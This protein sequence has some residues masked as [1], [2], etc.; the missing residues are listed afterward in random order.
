MNPAFQKKIIL[1]GA[2]QIVCLIAMIAWAALPVMIGTEVL[3][4]TRPVDPRDL[5]RGNYVALQYD[6]SQIPK[7]LMDAS[8]K[9][10]SYS[11]RGTPVFVRLVSSGPGQPWIA[12]KVSLKPFDSGVFLKGKLRY[13]PSEAL[14]IEYGLEAFYCPLEKAKQLE[15]EFAAGNLLGKVYISN[16]RSRLS[17]LIKWQSRE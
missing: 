11:D 10:I 12:D 9:E 17:D 16:G 13:F 3:L 1:A 14:D 5:F 2:F 4:K 8:E 6:I 15:R 7:E